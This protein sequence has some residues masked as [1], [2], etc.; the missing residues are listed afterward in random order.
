MLENPYQAYFYV[1]ALL[2]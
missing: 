2:C 1:S